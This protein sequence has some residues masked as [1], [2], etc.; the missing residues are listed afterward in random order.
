MKVI[1]LRSE[2]VKKLRAVEII[3]D[4]NVV[5]ISGKN[6]AGKTSVLDSIYYALTGKIPEKPIREGE[7]RA[8][9]VLDM[10]NYVIRRTITEKGSYLKVE[11]QDG[12]SFQSPQTMLN[13]MLGKLT[14]DP[15]EFTR[16]EK[17]K[18]RGVLLDLLNI[19]FGV[20]DKEKGLLYDERTMV[21]REV[22]KLKGQIDGFE[23]IEGPVPDDE[24]NV[25]A[26]VEQME[27]LSD[28][29]TAIED[30]KRRFKEKEGV[31]EWMKGD[32]R[33]MEAEIEKQKKLLGVE[34]AEAEKLKLELANDNLEA[35]QIEK[36]RVAETIRTANGTNDKIRKVKEFKAVKA[37]CD[38]SQAEYDQLSRKIEDIDN[39][40][41]AQ[42]KGAKM[43][44]SGL[45]FD[46]SGVLYNGIPFEQLSSAEQLKI[47][48]A[49]AMAMNP[50]IRIIRITDGSLLDSQSLQVIRDLANGNDYQVWIEQVDETGQ[51]GIY[52]EDGEVKSLVSGGV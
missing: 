17:Q 50:Q 34:E 21:G 41:I 42:I 19:D 30:R 35:I 52:I 39:Q 1:K 10:D 51:A 43:P 7:D 15:L 9:I 47:S 29:I 40:K 6:G 48:V 23:V 20:L 44:I 11:N 13:N 32:I 49:M 14:F 33:R 4:E 38:K 25:S 31:I 26:L 2:N 12:A 28:R 45:S 5:I 22:K 24:V 46:E 8:E 16:M 36:A 37:E 18:Q 3:P 27:G